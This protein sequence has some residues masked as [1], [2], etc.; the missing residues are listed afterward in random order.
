MHVEDCY[1]SR[2]LINDDN[3]AK[4]Y[5]YFLLDVGY[6]RQWCFCFLFV[7]K[8]MIFSVFKGVFL[9]HSSS[10]AP[11]KGLCLNAY[12]CLGANC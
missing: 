6:R 3:K 7:K 2:I 12:D 11:I 10:K 4:F 1:F 9:C 5:H 8:K